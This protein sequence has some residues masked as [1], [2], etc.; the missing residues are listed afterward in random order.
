[1]EDGTEDSNG[2]FSAQFQ[3]AAINK[4]RLQYAGNHRVPDGTRK[5]CGEALSEY[6]GDHA[7]ANSIQAHQPCSF[8]HEN[9]QVW[10]NQFLPGENGKV[11]AAELSGLLS[12]IDCSMIFNTE[13]PSSVDI[14]TSQ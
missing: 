10:S 8:G 11:E 2:R 7:K 6:T 5:F 14:S 13:K 4:N 9:S 1:M 12:Q 3:T